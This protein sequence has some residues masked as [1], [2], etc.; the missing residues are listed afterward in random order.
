M[1]EK[2]SSEDDA[3]RT[4]ASETEEMGEEIEN[5]KPEGSYK[6]GFEGCN[7][8]KMTGDKEE[9][10]GKGDGCPKQDQQDV[11][12]FEMI[13]KSE[14][15]D[16]E[17]ISSLILSGDMNI[18]I[19]L[20]IKLVRIFTSSTFTG[21]FSVHYIKLLFFIMLTHIDIFIT[22]KSLHIYTYRYI[23]IC[24]YIKLYMYV[25]LYIHTFI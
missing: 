3:S 11:E 19:P 24:I 12:K 13:I 25:C 10:N 7:V 1:S 18:E 5:K 2:V 8:S 16:K 15:S 4:S 14:D 6:I 22:C 20:Q 21:K 17:K 9:D 23:N